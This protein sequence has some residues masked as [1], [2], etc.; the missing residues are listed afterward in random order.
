MKATKQ[1]LVGVDEML[2]LTRF[3]V[4]EYNMQRR[5]QNDREQ[6]SPNYEM[7]QLLMP[8]NLYL[9]SVLST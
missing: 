8:L 6:A 3:T 2:L 9:M 5:N 4:K 1:F 7:S